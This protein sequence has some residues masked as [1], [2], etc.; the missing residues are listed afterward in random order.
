V[1]VMHAFAVTVF[2]YL[3]L[4]EKMKK[5]LLSGNLKYEINFV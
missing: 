3:K 5:S 4:D 1:S 2:F